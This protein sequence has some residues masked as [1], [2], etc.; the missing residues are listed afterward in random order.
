MLYM[1]TLWAPHEE[2]MTK[3]APEGIVSENIFGGFASWY[4]IFGA[5]SHMASLPNPLLAVLLTPN[6]P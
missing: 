1:N 6:D 4:L 2:V 3:Y 5:P